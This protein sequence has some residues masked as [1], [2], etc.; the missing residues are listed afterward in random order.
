[1]LTSA[2]SPPASSKIRRGECAAT[3]LNLKWIAKHLTIGTW[4]YL[5]H[6]T[7]LGAERDLTR[8][9][10]SLGRI[11]RDKINQNV[12]MWRADSNNNSCQ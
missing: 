6:V 10:P 7:A 12:P 4:K 9:P 2:V 11:Q 5:S 1:M 3:T 8:Q